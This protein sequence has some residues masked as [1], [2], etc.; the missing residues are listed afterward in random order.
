M[1]DTIVK[2]AEN[3]FIHQIGTPYD[4]SEE[5]CEMRTV[6]ASI[7]I[8]STIEQNYRV[9]VACDDAM[10]AMITELFLGEEAPDEETQTDMTLETANLIVGSA[11]VL[12][13]EC[14]SVPFTIATPIFVKRDRFD[15][16]CDQIRTVRSKEG[17]LTIG[18]KEQ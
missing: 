1:F 16:E 11:K 14:R 13:E 7:D 5:R 17:Q 15:I 6:I 9:Y 10:I 4:I 18:I 2:A 12:A 8:H 3:F